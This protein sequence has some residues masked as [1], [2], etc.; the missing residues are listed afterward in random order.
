MALGDGRSWAVS[1]RWAA[2]DLP[3]REQPITLFA[4]LAS[5]WLTANTSPGQV[6]V[7]EPVV[8]EGS[9]RR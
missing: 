5:G 8:F 4:R 1:P 3:S 2:A 9:C 6:D 7:E